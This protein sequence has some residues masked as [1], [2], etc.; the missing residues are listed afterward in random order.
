MNSREARMKTPAEIGQAILDRLAAQAAA[1]R[2]AG[3]YREVLVLVKKDPG[4][5]GAHIVA[6]LL[7]RLSIRG[8]RNW[9]GR[10]D[11]I[12][13]DFSRLLKRLSNDPA[14]RR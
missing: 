13:M 3:A 2:E 9:P 7:R 11:E 5:T 14:E 10:F 1:N 6:K 12:W 4:L 8:R